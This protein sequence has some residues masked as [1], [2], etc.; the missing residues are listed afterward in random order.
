MVKYLCKG[1]A[2]GPASAS[3]PNLAL[4]CLSVEAGGGDIP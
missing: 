2:L 1:V 4:E 3:A